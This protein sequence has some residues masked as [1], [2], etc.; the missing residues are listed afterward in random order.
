MNI[1]DSN[2]WLHVVSSWRIKVTTANGSTVKPS[3]IGQIGKRLD[4]TARCQ[5]EGFYKLFIFNQLGLKQ[6]IV[7]GL[8]TGVERRL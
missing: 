7:H 6:S 3:Y 5:A 8:F 2:G 1:D 4:V